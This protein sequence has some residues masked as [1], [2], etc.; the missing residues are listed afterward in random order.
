MV[1]M[2]RIRRFSKLDGVKD[3]SFMFQSLR[4]ATAAALENGVG[5]SDGGDAGGP[6]D[7]FLQ[8]D[9]VYRFFSGKKDGEIVNEGREAVYRGLTVGV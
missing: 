7:W 4:K 6:R 9:A 3:G 1:A 2:G 8:P 5:A